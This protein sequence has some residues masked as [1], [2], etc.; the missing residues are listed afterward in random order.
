MSLT[1]APDTEGTALGQLYW[2]DGEQR[3]VADN[4]TLI[5]YTY[6]QVL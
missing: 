6:N 5:S 4:Y 1:I 2:D 3:D